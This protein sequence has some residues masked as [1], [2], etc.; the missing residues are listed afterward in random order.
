MR[1]TCHCEEHID[2]A[3]AQSTGHFFTTSLPRFLTT[4]PYHHSRVASCFATLAASAPR[5]KF[6]N[7]TISLYHGQ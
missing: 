3:K 7:I 6:H 5:N 2:E 4:S 1:L